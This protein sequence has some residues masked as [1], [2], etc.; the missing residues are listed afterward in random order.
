MASKM[1]W[2]NISSG[3]RNKYWSITLQ[4]I[5][6][7]F[8][9]VTHSLRPIIAMYKS[10]LDTFTEK[11]IETLRTKMWWVADQDKPYLVKFAIENDFLLLGTNAIIRNL[12]S[13]ISLGNKTSH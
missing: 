1:G 3:N 10:L 6:L 4:N 11:Q 13:K 2:Y 7:M 8:I 5:F 12:R 9:F